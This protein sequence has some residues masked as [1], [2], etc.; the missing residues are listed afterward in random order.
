M[1][2]MRIIIGYGILSAGFIGCAQPATV[3]SDQGKLTE[4]ES[5]TPAA[6]QTP[7]PPIL[8][9][10]PIRINYETQP[11]VRAVSLSPDGTRALTAS[12]DSLTLWD[13]RDRTV[14]RP[15]NPIIGKPLTGDEVHYGYDHD[16]EVTCLAVHW[17]S[18]TAA[19]GDG[20]GMLRIWDLATGKLRYEI[21]AF[22]IGPPAFQGRVNSIAFSQ[23]GRTVFAVG[24]ES[25]LDAEVKS[26][27]LTTGT[28]LPSR[29]H[30]KPGGYEG[31]YYEAIYLLPGGR[32]A[33]LIGAGWSLWDLE[34]DKAVWHR[35]GIRSRVAATCDLDRFLVFEEELVVCGTAGERL[36]ALKRPTDYRAYVA[37]FVPPHGKRVLTAGATGDLTLWNVEDGQHRAQWD[38]GIPWRPRI[39]AIAFSADGKLGLTGGEGQ[40]LQ[41]WDVEK[42]KIAGALKVELGWFAITRCLRTNDEFGRRRI[43]HPDERFWTTPQRTPGADTDLKTHL[44]KLGAYYEAGKVCDQAGKELY[45]F[46][47][48]RPSTPNFRGN[49]DRDVL[50]KSNERRQASPI[51][52]EMAIRDLERTFRVVRMYYPPLLSKD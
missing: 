51:D 33:L 14:L 9:K 26:W 21:K 22:P 6:A 48:P 30:A 18:Q 34:M 38:S 28:R 45:F 27:D 12:G 7:E 3:L 23:D 19:V 39:T 2:A 25:T 16:R 15:F 47:M 17:K 40:V 52:L 50:D 35:E 29:A 43:L 41:L 4:A 5:R 20:K 37:A 44:V 31:G 8:P 32:R 1:K 10:T 49:K 42:G 36:R 24:D 46:S 11:T 13:V